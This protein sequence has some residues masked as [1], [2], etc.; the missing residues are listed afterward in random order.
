MKRLLLPA[1]FAA[2]AASAAELKDPVAVASDWTATIT[3]ASTAIANA[4]LGDQ[5]IRP[6]AENPSVFHSPDSDQTYRGAP[7]DRLPGRKQMNHDRNREQRPKGAKPYE[8]NGE[9]YWLVP[10]A[11]PEQVS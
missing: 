8:F 2:V 10:L 4:A 11:V 7:S 9:T 3:E 5:S 6:A 1:C